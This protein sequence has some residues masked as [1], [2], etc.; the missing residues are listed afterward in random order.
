MLRKMCVMRKSWIVDRRNQI[1]NIVCS[2]VTHPL[3]NPSLSQTLGGFIHETS[4]RRERE[5]EKEREIWVRP[6]QGYET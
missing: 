6:V 2:S 4:V 3:F 5:R 1:S